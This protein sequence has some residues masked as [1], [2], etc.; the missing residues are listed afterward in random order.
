MIMEDCSS[1]L[2]LQECFGKEILALRDHVEESLMV[3]GYALPECYDNRFEG[4]K[5]GDDD[6]IDSF[7]VR[8]FLA[9]RS[10]LWN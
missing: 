8:E 10:G 7:Q 9:W 3:N 4:K 6:N 5:V 2:A 1:H